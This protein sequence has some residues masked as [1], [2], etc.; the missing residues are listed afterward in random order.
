MNQKILLRL[1]ACGLAGTTAS[2]ASGGGSAVTERPVVVNISGA[3]L[4]ENFVRGFAS[5][6][7]FL[8][9]DRDGIVVDNVTDENLAEFRPSTSYNP[10]LWF[11]VQ[12]RATG[13]VNGYQELLDFGTGFATG[14]DAGDPGTGLNFNT[15]PNG[16]SSD[17]A[18]VAFCNGDLGKFLEVPSGQQGANP[19]GAFAV[20]ANT[21]HPGATPVKSYGPVAPPGGKNV[22]SAST[23]SDADIAQ[24]GGYRQDI[25]PLD[26][27]TTWGTTVPGTPN[28]DDAPF[29]GGYGLNPRQPVDA[30]GSLVSFSMK[31]VTV[32]SP[33]NFPG[34]ATP[35]DQFTIYDTPL[36]YAPVATITNYGTGYR[37]FR[38][39][40]LRHM[41]TTGRTETGENLTQ[42]N[43]SPGSGTHNAYSNSLCTDP[44]QGGGEFVGG[45]NGI[46]L[47]GS[48]YLPSNKIGSSDMEGALRNTRLGIGYT[49]A[50]RGIPLSGAAFINEYRMEYVG[51]RADTHGGTTYARPTI[52][53]VLGFSAVDTT[54]PYTTPPTP[55]SNRYNGYNIGG[56]GIMATLGDPRSSLNTVS[57][58]AA[59]VQAL[60]IDAGNTNPPMRNGYAAE[61]VNNI[62]R[63][64]EAFSVD[65]GDPSNRFTPGEFLGQTLIISGA[66][67][68]GQ[69]FTDPCSLLVPGDA[70]FEPPFFLP[71]N[72]GVIASTA[73]GN[74][75]ANPRFG[76]FG[77]D[78]DGL[79]ETHEFNGRTPERLVLTGTN[80][81]SDGKGTAAPN[82]VY[83]R[84]S[85]ATAGYQSGSTGLGNRNRVAGD[86]NGDGHRDSNDAEQLVRAWVDR[87]FARDNSGAV[88]VPANVWIP[89]AG[90]GLLTFYTD[91]SSFAGDQAIIEVLGDFNCD[92]NF[93]RKWNDGSA[94]FTA[95]YSDALYWA[96]GLGTVPVLDPSTPGSNAA[97][98]G[99]GDAR[100]ANFDDADNPFAPHNRDMNRMLAFQRLDQAWETVR[101]D[102]SL[103]LTIPPAGFVSQPNNF[104]GVALVRGTYDAGDAVADVAGGAGRTIGWA[105][106]AGD[107]I[108]NMTDIE[109]VRAQFL[110]NPNVA[111]LSLNWGE[112]TEAQFAVNA[113]GEI[114][115]DFTADING[116]RVID[117]SDA[118]KILSILETTSCD[119]NLDGVVDTADEAIITANQGITS[120]ALFSQGDTDHDGDVDM[121]DLSACFVIV[122][123]CCPGNADKIGPGQVNFADVTTVLSNFAIGE[124]ADDNGTTPGDADCNGTI[125]FAD[126]TSVLVNFLNACN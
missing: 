42:I 44:S 80:R 87:N 105:P 113:S 64:T 70:G 91:G 114:V 85:G 104:F 74:A 126:V 81:Y 123:P 27:P 56:P 86:F 93:G 79:Q 29:E 111:D 18:T 102:V 96:D 68:V 32:N 54:F 67:N 99:A 112:F 46:R 100:L 121:D 95:D 28:A 72:F 40:T 20:G 31:L 82:N 103:N 73:T 61:Y 53:N 83:V 11:I 19:G 69:T 38:Y 26:V 15:P 43:R 108:V 71:L 90:S 50:E 78:G 13:S 48:T 92:G 94:I 101:T 51:V 117:K 25:A 119:V 122:P 33:F 58:N 106:I 115:G 41:N 14:A 10:D 124:G 30:A 37:A 16:L 9:L 97:Y 35:D 75:L 2:V 52:L 12:Y 77:N 1:L 36:A 49:G 60:G 84:Q 120:G 22:N 23:Y 109:Y 5:T 34:D 116:D 4:M 66:R 107:R 125:N 76:I 63:S 8:D 3:T 24:P 62:T 6:N 45:E 21:Q 89:P 88:S 55:L 59:T 57:I 39:S 98:S 7:D 65:P 47:L 118:I 17:I 110:R